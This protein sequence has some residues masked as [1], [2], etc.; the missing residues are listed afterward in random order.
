MFPT[1]KRIR[2]LTLT[3]AAATMVLAACGG[4]G[5]GSNK[6]GGSGG[7]GSGGQQGQKVTITELDY[8]TTGGSDQAVKWY[9]KKFQAAHPNVTI[10]RTSV[11][12]ANLI[13]KV[14]QDASAQNMPNIVML[15]NPDV[16]QV[17]ATG[18]L[19]KFDSLPGYT[20]KGYFSSDMDEC[21]FSGS[22]YCYPIGTNSLG[23]FYNKKMLAN[24]GVK[25]PK[26]WQNLLDDAKALTKNGVYGFAFDATSDEQSTWQLEPFL[27]SNGGDLNK[28]NSPQVV[29]A[30]QLWTTLVSSGWAS[31]SVLQ[32][33][34]SPD[35]A[36]QFIHKRAAMVENGPWIFPLLN[37][38]GMKYGKDYGIVPMP[39]RV[40]GQKVI[41]PLGGETWA[42]GDSG[43]SAQQ[44][45]AWQWVKGMQAAS[46]MKHVTSLM[47]YL[48]TKP[49]ITKEVLQQGPEYTVFA[50]ETKTARARTLKLGDKYSK[51]SQ[52]V[53]TAIQAAVSGASSPQDALNT[54]Q[55]TVDSVLGSG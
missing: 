49:A 53:W 52:A 50:N 16:P 39:T 36:Q 19:R 29:Q 18:Q 4:S 41:A 20:T 48:P 2:G 34:Q 38:A 26:T 40:A 11:P 32:W 37:A 42:L 8:F 24:A 28:V 3:F 33:G 10:K 30:L 44:K 31:K 55:K 9:N 17:A 14:L 21:L 25:P 43:S 27:W 23:I 51:V 12:Y 13:T 1:G 5:G 46:T 7:G 22:H 15:D 35:L 54:A 45:A 47:Y 6:A